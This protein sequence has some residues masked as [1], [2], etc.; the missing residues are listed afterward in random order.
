MKIVIIRHARVDY[1]WKFWCNSYEFNRSCDEYDR[2]SID[3]SNKY[4][5]KTDNPIYISELSRSYDTAKLIFGE[6]KFIKMNLFN[7]VPIK[8]FTDKTI[9]LPLIIWRILGRI[10]WYM[11]SNNQIETKDTTYKRAKEAVDFLEKKNQDCFIICHACYMRVLLK[12]LKYRGYTGYYSRVNIMNLQKFT[13]V[14]K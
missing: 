10:Q 5:I 14:K 1:K 9:K 8:A 7:E 11:N 6:N 3:Y 12:E 4:N 2:S 13:L